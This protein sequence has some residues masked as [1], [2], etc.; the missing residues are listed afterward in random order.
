[1]TT[2]SH[3]QAQ[4]PATCVLP[5]PSQFANYTTAPTALVYSSL[6]VFYSGAIRT[7]AADLSTDRACAVLAVADTVAATNILAMQAGARRAGRIWGYR[8]AV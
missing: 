4:A 2:L 7:L 6:T 8:W 3:P 1:M 5:P